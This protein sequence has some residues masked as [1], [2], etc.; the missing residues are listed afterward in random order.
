M[1]SAIRNPRYVFATWLTGA[2]W[3]RSRAR[4]CGEAE[5]RSWRWREPGC[6]YRS[7]DTTPEL[8]LRVHG[9]QESAA[10]DACMWREARCGGRW[11]G[12]GR[13][14]ILR[15][16]A[17][18][19]PPRLPAA[20]DSAKSSPSGSSGFLNTAPKDRRA[21]LPTPPRSA[22]SSKPDGSLHPPSSLTTVA[23]GTRTYRSSATLSAGPY[24]R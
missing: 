12:D 19:T 10:R 7:V 22:P 18:R 4:R 20:A 15:A 23:L 11:E 2:D 9:L 3:G 6:C 8:G 13:S 24:S 1:R 21:V 5:A 16:T 17:V 14:L